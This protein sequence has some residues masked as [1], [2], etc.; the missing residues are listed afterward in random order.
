MICKFQC[1]SVNI[2]GTQSYLLVYKLSMV[3]SALQ[4]S[5]SLQ[6]QKIYYLVLYKKGFL[7]PA[8]FMLVLG[9]GGGVA[10][11]SL[12]SRSHLPWVLVGPALHA[13]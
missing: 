5:R 9:V 13:P 1:L 2:I 4:R 6:S 3:A 10:Q 12:T 11:A 7:V 8:M